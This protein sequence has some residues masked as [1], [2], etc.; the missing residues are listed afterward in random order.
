M[1]EPAAS[2]SARVVPSARVTKNSEVEQ[3]ARLS[4]L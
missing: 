4:T 2:M 1:S 3:P